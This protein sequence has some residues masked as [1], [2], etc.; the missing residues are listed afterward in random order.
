ME[1]DKDNIWV[2]GQPLC[3]LRA[4][5]RPWK[6]VEVETILIP[7]HPDT[8]LWHIRVHRLRT[9]RGLQSSDAGFSNYGQRKDERALDTIPQSELSTSDDSIL[10]GKVTSEGSDEPWALACSAGGVV[11]V[12]DLSRHYKRDNLQRRGVV[13]VLDPNT[14]IVFSRSVMPTLLGDHSGRAEDEWIVTGVFALPNRVGKTGLHK[15]AWMEEWVK[16]PVVP[17]AILKIMG[18]P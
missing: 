9:G 7:P 16:T 12:R 15:S 8:P 6:D 3:W 11:A 13:V 4:I 17:K 1:F 18:L 14:N 10:D 2:D 5:W